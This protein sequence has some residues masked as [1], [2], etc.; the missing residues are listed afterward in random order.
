MK[1]PKNNPILKMYIPKG[2]GFRNSTIQGGL[3]AKQVE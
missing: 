3:K 1:P 2:K